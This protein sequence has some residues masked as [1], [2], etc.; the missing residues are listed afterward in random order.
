[1]RKRD[2]ANGKLEKKEEKEKA[3]DHDLNEKKEKEIKKEPEEK[4]SD[5]CKYYC[6]IIIMA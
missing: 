5:I 2:P 1:M 3:K 4:G 6:F